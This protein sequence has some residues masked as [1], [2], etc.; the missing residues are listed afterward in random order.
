MRDSVME[1]GRF[2]RGRGRPPTYLIIL[3]AEVERNLD[4]LVGKEKLTT[5][6]TEGHSVAF[7]IS[8][9]IFR[10]LRGCL[11]LLGND[12]ALDFVVSG[13]RDDFLL[14]EIGFCPVGPAV[15]DFLRVRVTD[16]GQG[17]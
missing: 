15:D 11:C 5:E 2:T 14:H 3:Y 13:L 8:V 6:H 7:W 12:H 16:T 10:L 17:L 1:L 4:V 9:V